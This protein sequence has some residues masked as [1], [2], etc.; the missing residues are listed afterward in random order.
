MTHLAPGQRSTIRDVADLAGVSHATVS[1]YLN[2]RSYVSS[3]T[4][5]AIDRAVAA[6]GYVK[7]NTARA[8]VMRKNFSVALVV[9][10]HSDL[11]FDDPNLSGMA[12]GANATFSERGYQMSILIVESDASAAR[13]IEMIGG[14]AVDGAL[15][16]AMHIEDPVVAALANSG[17]PLVT[18]STPLA[19]S[20]V[21]S[22]DTDNVGGAR[23]ISERLTMSGR[24]RI[25]IINGPPEAPVTP[26]RY[27]GYQE[28]LGNLYDPELVVWA[29]AWTAEEGR[30]ALRDLLHLE[31]RLDAVVA[32][33]DALA[34]GVIDAAGAEGLSV[35]ADIAVVGFDD[36]AWAIR[37]TPQISTVRQSARQTGIRMAEMLLDEIDGS[38][39]RGRHEILPN[40]IVWRDS[41]G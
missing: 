12:I 24:Q 41:A 18:S 6:T 28:G 13:V 30:R 22:V 39:V 31:P 9:R 10:E 37:T 8:L 29:N 7:N 33:S 38:A 11:F 23:A 40:E 5:R 20:S 26:L 32:A 19:E 25:A 36:S 15:L 3:E 27:Q 2:G 21:T 34:A 1:R 4:G 16:L 35:P 14:G 17:T